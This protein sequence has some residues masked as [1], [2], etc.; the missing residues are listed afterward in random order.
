MPIAGLTTGVD[1]VITLTDNAT[2]TVIAIQNLMDFTYSE[3]SNIKKLT[4]A[5]GGVLVP[6]TYHGAKG[7]FSAV[8]GG[9]VMEN[10]YALTQASYLLGVNQVGL[11]ISLTIT[12]VSGNPTK[13][14]FSGVQI[15]MED[16][17]SFNGNEVVTQKFTF[18]AE[19]WTKIN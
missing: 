15:I 6:K 8:R 11:S 7:S 5:D 10:Y 3:D 12:E 19:A 17:G 2:N 16:A 9:P 14:Q 1:A 18:E 4:L 13:E